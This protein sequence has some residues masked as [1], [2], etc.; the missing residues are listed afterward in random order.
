MT[1]QATLTMPEEAEVGFFGKLVGAITGFLGCLS[2]RLIVIFAAGALLAGVVADYTYPRLMSAMANK[3]VVELAESAKKKP[4]TSSDILQTINQ[5]N[6]AWYYMTTP[7]GKVMPLTKPYAPYLQKYGIAPREFDWKGRHYYEAVEAVNNGQ[8]LHIGM[9]AGPVILPSLTAGLAALNAP[10]CL[11]YASFLV[12]G[13]MLVTMLALHAFVSRP[14]AHLTRACYSLLLTRDAYA[15]VTGGGLK[16][17]GAVT[18]V[19]NVS[20]GLKD[21]RRQYDEAVAA[22]AAKEEELKR[23]RVEHQEEKTFIT[24][25]YEEEIAQREAKLTE[26]HTKEAEEEFINALGREID[27]LKSSKQVVHRVLEKLNDK[28]PTSIIF[29]AFFRTGK[30]MD[31]MLEAYLGFDE[32]SVQLIKKIDHQGIAREILASG[33]YLM[34]G[35]GALRDYGFQQLA[36]TNSIRNI[37]YLPLKF[38]NRNLGMLAFYFVQEGHV[39]HERLRVLRNVVDLTARTLYQ[40]VLYEEETEASRTDPLTGLRNKKFFYEIMPQV[41]ERAAVNPHE[42]PISLIMIDGDHFKSINDTYGHQVGDQMLQELAKTIR[43]CVRTQDSLERSTGPGDYLIRYG[44]EE[45]VVVMEAADA[46]KAVSVAERIRQSVESKGDW[47]GGIARW[48]ISLG[49]ATYPQDGK[50]AEEL[51]SKSD[52][53]LY[54]VKEEL[55]RN[56]VCHAQQVPKAFKA[57][58][59]AAAIG[60]ELG[61]FDAAGLLQSIA[62][63]QKTG[64][65]TVQTGDNKQLWMLFENGKPIQARLGR[66]AGN[67]AVIEFL[68]TFEEGSFNFQERVQSGRETKL[69]KLED[70]YNVTKGLDR[71]L[72]DGALATDNFNASRTILPT[73][74]IYIRP[75]PQE[76]FNARWQAIMSL[77]EDDRPTPDEFNNMTEIVKRAD[78]STTLTKIF[79]QLEPTPIYH[80]WRAAALLYQHGLIQTKPA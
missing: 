60:G 21:I 76:E 28:F 18:E 78:G 14:L 34:I 73:S 29:G 57:K 33:Q 70:L 4:P 74:E 71:L 35:P 79:K 61:V 36:Q 25:Q 37:V 13:L 11:G 63:S 65:L 59:T 22:R 24:K 30:Q 43:Q 64:V 49:V 26:L 54:Y 47:P 58:K 56:K 6:L 39:V 62:T 3:L 46:R 50:N 75:V 12:V 7:D 8:I 19:Q 31:T 67:A 80:L 51:M 42:N 68:V 77:R 69:P 16:V 1:Y 15:H 17:P 40:V 5:Y 45:F 27:T 9:Y 2:V 44:G 48:T 41:F 52:T 23:S 72:M 66:M 53:A 10:V 20:K 38:Q 55:G 32:R